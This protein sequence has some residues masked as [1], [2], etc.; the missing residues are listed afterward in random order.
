MQ[1]TAVDGLTDADDSSEL[2]GVF[3]L[4]AAIEMKCGTTS[5]ATVRRKIATLL[6]GWQKREWVKLNNEHHK[7]FDPDR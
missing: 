2:E 7:Q 5:Q 3:L 1:Q 4:Q 6:T